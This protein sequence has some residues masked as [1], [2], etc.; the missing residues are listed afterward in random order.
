MGDVSCVEIADRYLRDRGVEEELVFREADVLGFLRWV[1]D[2]V[3][4]LLERRLELDMISFRLIC[5]TLELPRVL[6]RLAAL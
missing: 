3:G 5:Y 6:C 1:D 4:A 2:A